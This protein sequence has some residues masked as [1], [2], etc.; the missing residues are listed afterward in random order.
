MDAFIHMWSN[1][2][3]PRILIAIFSYLW[4]FTR[5]KFLPNELLWKHISIIYGILRGG[6]N[7]DFCRYKYVFYKMPYMQSSIHAHVHTYACIWI[8][9]NYIYHIKKILTQFYSK[10]YSY[11]SG[12]INM[13]NNKYFLTKYGIQDF[14]LI[15]D[16]KSLVFWLLVCLDMSVFLL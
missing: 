15:F 5:Q 3:P 4:M 10:F 7:T 16:I 12:R 9:M 2:S 1:T 11:F 14:F 6:R 13:G 8:H